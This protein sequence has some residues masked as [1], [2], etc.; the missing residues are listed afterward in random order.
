MG[1]RSLPIWRPTLLIV[2]S[3][4][5]GHDWS[6]DRC[7]MATTSRTIFSNRC[8]SR[9]H[10]YNQSYDDLPPAKK[11]DRSMRSLLAIVANIADRSHVRLIATNRTIK[12]SYDRVWLW[13]YRHFPGVWNHSKA[14]RRFALMSQRLRST[15]HTFRGYYNKSL[16]ANSISQVYF[17]PRSAMK[18]KIDH[19]LI[20]AI[21]QAQCKNNAVKL[22]V[23][24]LAAGLSTINRKMYGHDSDN[25]T[26]I[27][28]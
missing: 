20:V 25:R 22:T 15:R 2:R 4:V 10:A 17:A 13:L 21:P 14:G 5:G 27:Y 12:Q 28:W 7:F 24:W 3:I 9:D 16:Q 1:F 6:Y 8:W 26:I 18:L 11:T 23:K 19:G